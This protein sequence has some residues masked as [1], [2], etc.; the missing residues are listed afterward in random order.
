M[1]FARRLRMKFS[2]KVVSLKLNNAEQK[3]VRRVV[4]DVT[5]TDDDNISVT[6][7]LDVPLFMPDENTFT[8]YNNLTEEQVLD[9]VIIDEDMERMLVNELE[10]KK[11]IPVLAN[12]PWGE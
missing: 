10:I 8:A 12:F 2:K 11:S 1:I 4:V 5:L 9:W 7:T 3:I 6:S